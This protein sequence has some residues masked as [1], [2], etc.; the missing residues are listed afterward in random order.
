MSYAFDKV[1]KQIG[2][3]VPFER[4]IQ[5]FR[6]IFDSY[7]SKLGATDDDI[8]VG[9]VDMFRGVDKEIIIVT[10][11]RNSVVD[12]L[13]LLGHP[14]M[15]LLAMTRAKSFFWVVGNSMT[16]SYV[17]PWKELLVASRLI[18]SGNYSNYYA[19][20]SFKDWGRGKLTSLI[21][22]FIRKESTNSPRN[23]NSDR[24]R[25]DGRGGGMMQQRNQNRGMTYKDQLETL[26][27]R[28]NH[29][30]KRDIRQITNSSQTIGNDFGGGKRKMKELD[31]NDVEDKWD[32]KGSQEESK[33]H[34]DYW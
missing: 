19:F 25:Q 33:E 28:N 15:I 17:H 16:Y 20:D 9:T 23:G 2:I 11:L 31:W 29:N 4:C 10:N 22:S 14:D 3:I 6:M 7:K 8:F 13:G 21:R 24:P 1:K 5:S 32:T 27:Q 26:L 12:G 30:R 18:S 34:N